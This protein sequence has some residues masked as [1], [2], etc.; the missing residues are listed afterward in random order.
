MVSADA[1]NHR[2][3]PHHDPVKYMGN[4][5]NVKANVDIEINVKIKCR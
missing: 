1:M 5:L 4:G 2:L 3:A